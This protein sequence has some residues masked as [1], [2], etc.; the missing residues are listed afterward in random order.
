ME[1]MLKRNLCLQLSMV[2][3][4]DALGLLCIFWRWHLHRVEGKMDSLQILEENIMPS[5][6]KLKLWFYWTFQK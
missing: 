1:H 6:R 3:L 2:G 5:V 4:C